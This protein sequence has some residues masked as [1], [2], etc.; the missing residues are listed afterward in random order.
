MSLS[1][2]PQTFT[3]SIIGYVVRLFV[4][5]SLLSSFTL[6]A[7]AE[8]I[9]QVQADR[10]TAVYDVGDPVTFNISLKST[11]VDQQ[12]L[13][14][15][16]LSADGQKPIRKGQ[17]KLING[18]AE[19]SGQL[20]KP[21]FL[22]CQVVLPKQA[23]V[24]EEVRAL[25]AAAISPEAIEPSL[26]VPDDFDDYWEQQLNALRSLP[27]EVQLTPVDL[28]ANKSDLLLFDLQATTDTGIQ[29]SG[30]LSYPKGASAGSLPALLSVHGAGV[31][32]SMK[33]TWWAS[34][35]IIALDINAHG[36][37]NGQSDEFYKSL[38]NGKLKSYH[39]K[40]WKTREA[41]YFRE[42]FLRVIAA[43]DIL[44]DRPEWDGRHLIIFGS[45]QGGAQ[46][47]AAAALDSRVT[48]SVAGVSAMC[49][50]SGMIVGRATGW[51]RSVPF[52]SK[53]QPDT[54]VLEAIRYYD[55]VNFA[56]RI[57]AEVAMTVGFID[58]TCPPTTVYAAYNNLNTVKS[59]FNDLP[60]GHK[61]SREANAFMKAAVLKHIADQSN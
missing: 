17:A 48:L 49:D 16:T 35:D 36:I 55:M 5:V 41:V 47:L 1:K 38:A 54:E 8:A 6:S 46:S 15:W 52:D 25:G 11:T 56:P 18:V 39:R 3:H 7:S 45:S 26:P 4:M 2:Y 28:P 24:D 31:R 9:L 50:L 53:R 40:T 29:I 33:P 23:T 21:G 30:Y 19:V 13:I 57:N 61:N 37:P 60:S 32:S 44:T 43:L 22:Q 51:P 12:A 14:N 58:R 20:D 59:M 42:M 27:V 10:A 34:E